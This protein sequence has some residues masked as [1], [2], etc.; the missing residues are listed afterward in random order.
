MFFIF[1]ILKKN[2]CFSYKK[3]YPQRKSIQTTM[4]IC[5]NI[6]IKTYNYPSISYL[7]E[8]AEDTNMDENI[9]YEYMHIISCYEKIYNNIMDLVF[10][11]ETLKE[12]YHKYGRKSEEILNEIMLY[13]QKKQ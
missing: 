7:R 10:I 9:L 6:R 5:H 11:P 13:Y 2:F 12:P 4:S 3:T 1:K 8:Y